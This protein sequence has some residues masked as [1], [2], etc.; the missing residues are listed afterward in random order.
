VA[1]DLEVSTRDLEDALDHLRRLQAEFENY[2]RRTTREQAE[3]GVF[4]QAQ[5]VERLLP[6]LDDLDRACD[7][8]PASE[9]ETSLIQGFCLVRDKFHQVLADAGLERVPAVGEDFDP[10]RHEALLTE[11]VEAD[12]AG[13]VL[14]EFVAGYAFKGKMVRPTRVKVGLESA[15]D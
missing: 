9:R 11:P 2:R 4:A 1:D 6:V 3:T 10:E 12:R 7:A 8:V 15:G 13:K 5:L 14:E